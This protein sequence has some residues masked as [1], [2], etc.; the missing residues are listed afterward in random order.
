MTRE[1]GTARGG[2]GLKRIRLANKRTRG[3]CLA[4]MILKSE[5]TEGKSK[6]KEQLTQRGL[7]SFFTHHSFICLSFP[8][9]VCAGTL[10]VWRLDYLCGLGF[11]EKSETICI[12]FFLHPV[13]KKIN[14]TNKKT[15]AM[16]DRCETKK[17]HLRL[18]PV[19]DVYT[20][21]NN[22]FKYNI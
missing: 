3:L 5:I 16:F 11:D 12:S 9:F 10:V 18:W 19:L 6:C 21:F 20:F 22:I 7:F 17:I 13:F 15:T 4:T 8:F 1:R 14:Q 2:V